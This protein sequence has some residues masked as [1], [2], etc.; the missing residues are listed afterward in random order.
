MDISKKIIRMPVLMGSLLLLLLLYGCNGNQSNISTSMDGINNASKI[1]GNKPI[2]F[3]ES[4]LVVDIPPQIAHDQNQKKYQ[5]SSLLLNL[6]KIKEVV[7]P[8]DISEITIDRP[9]KDGEELTTKDGLSIYQEDNGTLISAS[10]EA[11]Y[12]YYDILDFTEDYTINSSVDGELEFMSRKL[13]QEKIEEIIKKLGISFKPAEIQIKAYTKK[14]FWESIQYYKDNPDYADFVSEES[15]ERNW[16][17]VD[18]VYYAKV[19]FQKDGIPIEPEGYSLLD[20]SVI[21]G[22]QMDFLLTKDGI[23]SFSFDS[24]LSPV[25]EENIEIYSIQELLESIVEKYNNIITES[26][27][28]IVG[29]TMEYNILPEASNGELY[30]VP[31]IRFET[32]EVIEMYTAESEEAQMQTIYD[33]IRVNAET[34]RI[35]E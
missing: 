9:G 25:S 17:L 33:V 22:T 7:F 11:S 13:V 28:S 27:P 14:H 32:R 5:V 19:N 18:E 34:G 26:K 3:E 2:K 29:A 31:I 30:L 15:F 21:Y 16:D 1:D 6:K 12:V 35:I 8:E 24:P 23:Q 20:E 4:G 10:K